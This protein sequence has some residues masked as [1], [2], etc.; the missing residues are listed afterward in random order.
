[1]ARCICCTMRD[2]LFDLIRYVIL[3]WTF[4][5]ACIFVTAGIF[6]EM[7]AYEWTELTRAKLVNVTGLR[8]AM[9]LVN[10]T[11]ANHTYY[12]YDT[13]NKEYERAMSIQNNRSMYQ[14]ALS[15]VIIINCAIGGN[16]RYS[17]SYFDRGF[18]FLCVLVY[19]IDRHKQMTVYF[20]KITLLYWYFIISIFY[21]I[22]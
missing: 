9:K 8:P 5:M 14:H 15:T 1:M 18:T 17:K 19:N 20:H 4:S 16:D 10:N 3:G 11:W 6:N 13:S 22:R 21:C 12:Q 2:R 7:I